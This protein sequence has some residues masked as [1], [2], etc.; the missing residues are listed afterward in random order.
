M[1]DEFKIMSNDLRHEIRAF[2]HTE[3]IGH[4][5]SGNPDYINTLKNTFA[6]IAYA[7]L[8]AAIQELRDVLLEDLPK[9]L[10]ELGIDKVTVCVVPRAKAT[11]TPE[12]LLFKSTVRTVVNQLDG[13]CD[14]TD[15]IVRNKD[16]KTT[17][18][19]RAIEQGRMP[20]YDNSGDMPHPGITSDTC[21][22]SHHIIDKDI[23]LVD[24]LYTRTVNIDED[25]IQAL[26]NNGAK[27][28][29]FYAVGRTAYRGC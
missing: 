3:Y 22:L 6:D 13:F 7:K 4:Q 16:T 2:Y 28:V 18:L 9:I 11:Y 26:L 17:H 27:S 5:Q 20:N 23:L 1:P 29:A 15:Y 19:Q 8:K 21:D 24:D 14:G 10:S 12:Q 25:V